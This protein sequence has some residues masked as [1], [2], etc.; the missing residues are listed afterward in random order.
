MENSRAQSETRPTLD[1]LDGDIEPSESHQSEEY[2]GNTQ[3]DKKPKLPW[4]KTPSPWW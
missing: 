3:P 1:A 2:L 4:W